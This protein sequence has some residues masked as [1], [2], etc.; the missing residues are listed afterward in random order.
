MNKIIS[1]LILLV[2]LPLLATANDI[3]T[4]KAQWLDTNNQAIN[5]HGGGIMFHNGI[6]YWYGEYKGDF[7]YRSPGVGWECYRTDVVG[8][9]CYSSENLFHACDLHNFDFIFLSY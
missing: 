2:S 4:P 7:T 1:T 3:I 8:V 6:Y 9:S 5:A